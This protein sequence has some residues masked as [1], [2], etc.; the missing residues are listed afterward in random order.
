MPKVWMIR[1]DYGSATQQVVSNGFHGLGWDEMGDL[2][3][4]TERNQISV[5][6]ENVASHL[7]GPATS[8]SVVGIFTRFVLDMEVGD[9]IITPEV[10]ARWLRYGE[11]TGEYTWNPDAPDSDGCR[12]M[13]RRS[14]RWSENRLDRT[15]LS[16]GF[17]N[18][19][20]SALTVFR[21]RHD[22]EF[23][24]QIGLGSHFTDIGKPA[25]AHAQIENEALQRVLQLSPTDFEQ[26][27]GHLLSAMGF[28]IEVTQPANGGGVDFRGV[29]DVSN[30]ARISVTGQVKRYALGNNIGPK[31]ILDLRG[32]IPIGAQG[33]FVTTSDYSKK[34]REVSEEVGFPRVGLVNGE[35]F[36]DFLTQ[37]WS[38]IPEEFRDVLGLKP[39]LV[40]T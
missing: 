39:G 23:F 10:E 14:V 30:V 29:L 22:A 19:L 3:A 21:V 24:S 28:D 17:R 6:R 32:R 33:T 37:H 7:E 27:V 9:W 18:S 8:R 34:A 5:W 11:V 13:H 25:E 31:P 40:P 20:Q 38:E 12:Y 2:S 4:V 16:L 26:L 35:Q 1:A 36:V 15:L